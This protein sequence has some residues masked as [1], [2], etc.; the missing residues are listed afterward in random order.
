[1]ADKGKE[2]ATPLG[3]TAIKPPGWDRTG[4]EAFKYMLWNPETGE[5]LTRT[6]MSW[7][8]IIVFYCIYYSLLA[9]FWVAALHIF[10][11]TLPETENGP[12]WKT[13]SSLIGENPGVGLR[14]K[15]SD[16]R[17]DSQMFVLKIGDDSKV[18]S[19]REG[20]GDTNAD[21][22]R[23][24][25]KFLEVYESGDA[26]G[27]YET[28]NHKQEL[29]DFC[30][31]FPYG[32]V[33][34]NITENE[35][36]TGAVKEVLEVAPCIIL[37]LNTIWGWVPEPITDPEYINPKMTGKD[38]ELP[39]TIKDL[40]NKLKETN[41]H[42]NKI[43]VDCS[44]RYPADQEALSDL[45]YFPASQSFDTKYFPYEGRGRWDS[46]KQEWEKTYHAPLIAIKIKPSL[47]NVG[48][49]VHIQCKAYYQ[50]VFHSAKEKQ[51]MVQFE[52]QVKT[53]L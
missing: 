45:E 27:G 50:N 52:V 10:F 12:S 44:G 13:S 42:E 5:I 2:E 18:P 1:M 11:M 47:E 4:F 28:F 51:G 46:V 15:N 17:I 26:T 53:F 36:G 6:P 48:Q 9:G 8:K 37:K 30:S 25:E 34:R 41:E 39:Q 14:P 38:A 23:R 43:W 29:G 16:E 49:L 24:L 21:Y 40:I 3:G 22:A 32:Y 35:D 33:Q 20:E 31:T 19:H 7:A